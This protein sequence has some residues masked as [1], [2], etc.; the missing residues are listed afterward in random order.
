MTCDEASFETSCQFG[1]QFIVR[2]SFCSSSPTGPS[3]RSFSLRY[4][5]IRS[6]CSSFGLFQL[7]R[8]PNLSARYPLSAGVSGHGA[9][10]MPAP[11]EV[12]PSQPTSTQWLGSE[13][14]LEAR[15]IPNGFNSCRNQA[16]VSASAHFTQT[17]PI[18]FRQIT[19]PTRPKRPIRPVPF[20]LIP[21]RSGGSVAVKARSSKAVIDWIG[22]EQADPRR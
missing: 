22:V 13:K 5:S 3:S 21:I 4:F 7:P 14:L 16:S 15:V 11:G 8:H 10:S 1:L 19:R 12:G 20:S 6:E 9:D 18:V 2:S 17:S